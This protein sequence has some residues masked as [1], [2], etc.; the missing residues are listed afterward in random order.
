MDLV[1]RT[2]L[3]SIGNCVPLLAYTVYKGQTHNLRKRRFVNSLLQTV[4]VLK[5][6]DGAVVVNPSPLYPIG[7]EAWREKAHGLFKS[8]DLLPPMTDLPL[9]VSEVASMTQ[10]CV[11]ETSMRIFVS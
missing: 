4:M 7:S 5:L 1:T 2:L 8:T 11:S 3:K 6:S 10:G 9:F